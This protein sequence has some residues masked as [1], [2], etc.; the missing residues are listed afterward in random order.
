MNT[1]ALYQ[2]FLERISQ[3]Q[4]QMSDWV[5]HWAMLNTGS[6]NSTGI[7]EFVHIL[8][9]VFTPLGGEAEILDVEPYV[10]RNDLGNNEA[11]PLGP[12]L[13]IRKR[14]NAARRVL[15]CIHTDTV[16]GPDHP[17]QT[18][19]WK[20]EHTLHGPGVADAKSGIAVIRIALEALEQSPFAEHIGW[21]VL[22]NPDEEIASPGSN[23]LLDQAAQ[24]NHVGMVYEPCLPGGELIAQRKGSGHVIVM[25]HGRSA[26]AGRNPH[27]GRNAVIALSEAIGRIAQLNGCRPGLTLNVGTVRGG[28]APNR[29]PDFAMTRI[30]MRV[31]QAED[32]EYTHEQ[33]EAIAT[34]FNA[35]DGYRME[36]ESKLTSPPKPV[37]SSLAAYMEEVTRCGEWL[38]LA[39]QWQNSGGVCD[40]NRLA[41]AGLPTID[42]LGPRG[43][44]LHSPDEILDVPSLV[45]RATLSALLLMRWGAGDGYWPAD[46]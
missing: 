39:V 27:E 37:T 34:D 24:R 38:G 18:V 26:H 25:M 10:R 41:A 12:A 31:Q 36:V 43:A 13:S 45:E 22:L 6:F 14:P 1:L 3:R 44:C 9:D 30:N 11:F 21:E 16:Y 4:T 15:L 5:Q 28:D 7:R 33:I 19:Q 2:P 20:D 23:S 46:S 40:G 42:T 17:F 29:V 32:F 35:R 8:H